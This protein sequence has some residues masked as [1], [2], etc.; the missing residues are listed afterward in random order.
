MEISLYFIF[1]LAQYLCIICVDED[2]EFHD[3]IVSLKEMPHSASNNIISHRSISPAVIPVAI[4]AL[5]FAK[6]YVPIVYRGLKFYLAS[7]TTDKTP[8]KSIIAPPKIKKPGRV[9]RFFSV[10]SFLKYVLET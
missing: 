8:D 1:I 7:N 3:S 6:D 4:T 10:S 9:S 5:T 2:L